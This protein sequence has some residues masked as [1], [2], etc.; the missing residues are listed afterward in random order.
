M[1][2]VILFGDIHEKKINEGERGEKVIERLK[3][4]R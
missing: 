4:R 3:Y 2:L 1:L